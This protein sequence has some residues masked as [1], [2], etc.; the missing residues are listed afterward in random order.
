MVFFTKK[1]EAEKEDNL[2]LP[3]LPRLPELDDFNDGDRR[4]HKL[5]SLP[6]SSY[7]T[8]FSQDT[9]KEAVT[10][11]REDGFADAEESDYGDEDDMRMMQEPLRKPITTE[12]SDDMPPRR[13]F[14][15]RSNSTEPIFVRIDLFEEALDTFNEAK[16]KVSG[17]E[18]DLENLKRIREKEENELKTWESE[19][20]SMKNQI[21][22][23]ERDV[24]S[25][26]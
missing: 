24:F 17:M 10:G 3:E 4:I 20:K 6:Q 9:I 18:K 5:P 8:K 7:G 14:S 26:I 2:S 11:E 23:V 22:K 25:K 13:N 21:E 1:K 19:I 12:I 16:K 15:E